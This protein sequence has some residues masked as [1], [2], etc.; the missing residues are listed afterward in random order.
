LIDAIG[1]A[2]KDPVEEVLH[3]VRS[4]AKWNLTGITS[5]GDPEDFGGLNLCQWVSID[6]DARLLYYEGYCT[7]FSE[8]TVFL[9]ISPFD[10]QKKRM[11]LFCGNALTN[12][13]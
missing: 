5:M 4:K 9:S 11:F 10:T 7:H 12:V 6:D 2:Y 8:R 3:V 1:V 13:K